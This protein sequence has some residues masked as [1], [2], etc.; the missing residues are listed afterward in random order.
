M[1]EAQDPANFAEQEPANLAEAQDPANFAEQ[2][3]DNLAEAQDPANFAEQEP[4]NLAELRSLPTWPDSRL[5]HHLDAALLLLL[6]GL[7]GFRGLLQG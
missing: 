1:A 5:E 7:V 4:A 6:E 2:E 3:P